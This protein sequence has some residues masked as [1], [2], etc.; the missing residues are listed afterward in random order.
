MLGFSDAVEAAGF[1]LGGGPGEHAVAVEL[2]VGGMEAAAHDAGGE[3]GEGASV[4]CSII[5]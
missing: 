3:L 4:L 5:F 2:A 1:L